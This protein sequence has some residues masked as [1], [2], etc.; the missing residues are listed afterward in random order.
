MKKKH[1]FL[2]QY[3]RRW[4]QTAEAIVLGDSG[5]TIHLDQIFDRT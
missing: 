4:Q 3:R 5:V 2:K 1:L